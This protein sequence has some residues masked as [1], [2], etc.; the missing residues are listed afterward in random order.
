VATFQTRLRAALPIA[1]VDTGPLYAAINSRDPDHRRCLDVLRRKELELV[2]PAM[3]VTE[4]TYFLGART[5][6]QTEAAFLAGLHGFRVEAPKGD[7]WL[8]IAELV[9]EYADFPL[10]GVDASVAVLA[11]C[12]GTSLLITLDHRHFATIRP[13]HCDA[14]ELLPGGAG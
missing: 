12:L 1:V 11:E 13:K 8:R 9:T 5:D 3:V 2:I 4:V 7:D 14:F 10:G 6:P